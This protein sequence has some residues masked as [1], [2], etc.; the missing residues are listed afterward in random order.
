MET[1]SKG[2]KPAVLVVEDDKEERKMLEILFRDLGFRVDS[3]ATYESAMRVVHKNEHDHMLVIVDIHLKGMKSGFDLVRAIKEAA[4]DRVIS[5]VL[6]GDES[7]VVD[8]EAQMAGAYAVYYKAKDSV[9]RLV[10]FARHN[11]IWET[12]DKL[13]EDEMTKLDNFRQFRKK[14]MASLKTTKDRKHPEVLSIIFID[15]DN[16]KVL[17]DQYGTTCGDE[18]IREVARTLKMHVRPSDYLCRK[19]GAGDE[20]LVLL[21]D[22]DEETA[23]KIGEK[24]AQ[25]VGNTFVSYEEHF[26]V[27][28][29]V[30][31]GAAQIRCEEI[32]DPGEGL[33]ELIRRANV[34]LTKA[35]EVKKVGR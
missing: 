15:I 3:C 11:P 8:Q 32:D 1:T 20:F 9:D 35:K 30:S 18:V 34:R 25:Q 17:N 14:S 33:T 22:T 12:M 26:K 16:F 28:F 21:P 29:S 19:A 13:A 27:K 23:A 7:N 24:Y 10:T 2:E 5:I 31:F 6:T 4:G